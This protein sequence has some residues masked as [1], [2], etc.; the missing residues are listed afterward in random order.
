MSARAIVIGAG[1]DE[2]MAAHRLSRA[3]FQVL[4]LDRR[5]AHDRASLQAGWIPERL[6]AELRLAEQGLQVHRPDPWI[7]VALPRGGRLELW[8]D[9]QRSV[10]AIRKLSERDAARWPEFCA[11]AA[12]VAGMLA[13]LYDAPP[14]DPLAAGVAGL[15]GLARVGL[16]VRR[17]GRQGLEDLMRWLPMP[18][19]DLLDEWFESDAL[20]AALGAGGLLHLAQ[21]PRSGG[22]AFGLLHQHV[23][24]AAGVFRPALSNIEAVLEKV[25]SVDIRAGAEVASI[26]VAKGRVEGVV[27]ST[28]EALPASVI[29]SGADPQRTLLQWVDTA[30]LDPEFTRAVR[31]IR[32]RGVV[33]RVTLSL[34]RPLELPPLVLAPSLDYLERAYEDAKHGKPSREPFLEARPNGAGR[35]AVHVQYTPYRLAEGEWSA[36]RR[37]ALGER[38]VELLAAR[39]PEL[40]GAITDLGVRT[41]RD[42]EQAEDWPEG[43]AYQAE[44]ALDQVLWMRPVAGWS[45]YRAPVEGLYLCGPAT[46]PGGGICGASGDHC[47]RQVLRDAAR[48]SA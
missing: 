21:G 35:I 12:R 39:V 28:G 47:A 25:A 44:L 5:P 32:R 36:A 42:L 15:A 19:A 17:L 45:R 41:P 24:C 31:N 40:G 4:V 29:V 7:A 37:Q 1:P 22:T 23:G 33:A 34:D 8:R 13:Y 46:H 20:K 2:L 26:A 6:V 16:K 14:P 27:L 10:E 9:M 48:R 18:V 43:Q 3:G 38:V 30:W 11:R